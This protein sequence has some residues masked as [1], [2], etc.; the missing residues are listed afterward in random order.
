MNTTITLIDIAVAAAIVIVLTLTTAAVTGVIAARRDRKSDAKIAAARK[1]VLAAADTPD[2]AEV[3][4]D[5]E[6]YI[7]QREREYEEDTRR[8]IADH[9]AELRRKREAKYRAEWDEM[10]EHA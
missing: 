6:A 5:V 1:R 4:D 2:P 3:P 8:F 9:A 7:R 10:R